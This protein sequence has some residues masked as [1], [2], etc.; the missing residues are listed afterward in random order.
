MRNPNPEYSPEQIAKARADSKIRME[1][2][3]DLP[4]PSLEEVQAQFEASAKFA[5]EY[6]CD[7]V[8]KIKK[9]NYIR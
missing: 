9:A 3:K 7:D 8:I 2:L 4:P 6:D 5:R 1:K